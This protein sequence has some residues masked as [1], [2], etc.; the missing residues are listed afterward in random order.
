MNNDTLT[1]KH[2][3]GEQPVAVVTRYNEDGKIVNSSTLW[4]DGT[5]W[6]RVHDYYR[7]TWPTVEEAYAAAV[8]D[9]DRQAEIV[10]RR[11][12]VSR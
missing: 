5:N 8:K 1:Y 10:A 2:N 4:F 12:A 7:G 6:N 11:Q 3:D 9:L